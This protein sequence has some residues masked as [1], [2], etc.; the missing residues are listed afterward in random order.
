ML[1]HWE[2]RVQLFKVG[3]LCGGAPPPYCEA[4]PPARQG[5]DTS[6]R[7][8]FLTIIID[9][10]S[11]TSRGNNK[12]P[13]KAAIAIILAIAVSR[14]GNER[15]CWQFGSCALSSH[16]SGGDTFPSWLGSTGRRN[17]AQAWSSQHDSAVLSLCCTLLATCLSSVPPHL[18]LGDEELWCS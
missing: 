1:E 2:T 14:P 15:K 6:G 16:R 4:H 18:G 17:G 13:S 8:P 9:A 3:Q 5:E 7:W 10:I 11:H 12:A